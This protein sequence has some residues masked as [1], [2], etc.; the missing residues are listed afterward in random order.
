MSI[1]KPRYGWISAVPSVSKVIDLRRPTPAV[2]RAED[3]CFSFVYA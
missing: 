2:E 3:A 1:L